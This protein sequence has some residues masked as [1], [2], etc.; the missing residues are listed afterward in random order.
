MYLEANLWKGR[1]WIP[2]LLWESVQCV[3][4]VPTCSLWGFQL[5]FTRK[6]ALLLLLHCHTQQQPQW[7]LISWRAGDSRNLW[8]LPGH[9]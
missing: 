9:C 2:E 4:C 1:H 7:H 3:P 6:L 5:R 8:L